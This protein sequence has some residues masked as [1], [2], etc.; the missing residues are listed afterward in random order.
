ML[1]IDELSIIKMYVGFNQD[2]D[3]I[4]SVLNDILP[5]IEE[6]EIKETVESTIRKANAMTKEAFAA[7]DLSDTFETSGL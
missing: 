1:T 7:I 2:R 6:P 3:V 5:L 4:V